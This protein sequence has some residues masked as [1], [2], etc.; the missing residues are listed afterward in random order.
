MIT[1]HPW[2][3]ISHNDGIWHAMMAGSDRGVGAPASEEWLV[4][5]RNWIGD[6]TLRG[7]T[8]TRFETKAE[9]DAFLAATEMWTL[10]APAQ[11]ELFGAAP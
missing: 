4:E 2:S 1:A 3:Y 6:E 7:N 8:V 5:L 9:H 10:P 11:A